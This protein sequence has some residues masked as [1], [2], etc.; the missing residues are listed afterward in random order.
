MIVLEPIRGCVCVVGNGWIMLLV[1]PLVNW[2]ITGA[3]GPALG[4][5]PATWTAT[6]MAKAGAVGSGDCVS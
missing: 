4:G 1:L 6:D 3:V 5:L 2:L